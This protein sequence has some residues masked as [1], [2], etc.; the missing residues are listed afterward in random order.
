MDDAKLKQLLEEDLE[1][2][3]ERIMAEVNAD[4]S[5]KDIEVP[6]EIHDN[7]MKRIRE[8]EEQKAKG[9]VSDEDKELMQFGRIYKKN[10]KRNRILM[11]LVAI[12]VIAALGMTSMGGPV[13]MVET[14]KRI[15]SGREQTNI[16]VGEE[17]I[18]KLE[19]ATEEE[20]YQA[21]EDTFNCTPVK[22]NA[23]PEGI[24][25]TEV[26]IEKETQNARLCYENDSQGVIMYTMLFSYRS[27]ATSVDVEDEIAKEVEKEID[28]NT[29]KIKQ[30]TDDTGETIRWRIEF[31]YSKVQYFVAISGLDEGEVDSIVDNLFFSR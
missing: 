7:L 29:V 18:D 24:V 10:R 15:V 14:M 23:L 22:L 26:V 8:Y 17:G 4:P 1:K 19:I 9:T 30:Y 12:I 28:G 13:K 16:Q 11:V 31:E 20:A 6:D 25:F 5:L 2:D 21:I 3:A 27:S